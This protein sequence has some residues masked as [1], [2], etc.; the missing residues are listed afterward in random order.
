MWIYHSWAT[1]QLFIIRDKATTR[2]RVKASA[3]NYHSKKLVTPLTTTSRWRPTV[4]ANWR[5]FRGFVHITT[6][7]LGSIQPRQN[8]ETQRFRFSVL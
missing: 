5:F 6:V 8:L 4:Y 2:Q 3:M 1:R 7:G